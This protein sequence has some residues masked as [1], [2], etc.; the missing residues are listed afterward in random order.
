MHAVRALREP[1]E[2]RAA[3]RGKAGGLMTPVIIEDRRRGKARP[4]AEPRPS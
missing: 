4:G 1:R 3:A 2:P